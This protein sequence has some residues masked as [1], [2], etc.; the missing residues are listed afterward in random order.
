[1]PT[2]KVEPK[3]RFLLRRVRDMIGQSSA[4]QVWFSTE[5]TF[6]HWATWN[7]HSA[8]GVEVGRC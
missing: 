8:S 7:L 5:R 2:V 4:L 1:M 3:A 6:I